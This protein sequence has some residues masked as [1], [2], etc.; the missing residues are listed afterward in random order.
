MV[1]DKPGQILL[2]KLKE[3]YSTNSKL[4][5]SNGTN[6]YS[7]QSV[8]S[9]TM[10]IDVWAFEKYHNH[11]GFYL[12]IWPKQNWMTNNQY[13]LNLRSIYGFNYFSTYHDYI[14]IAENNGYQLSNIVALVDAHFPQQVIN[15][16]NQPGTRG[17]CGFYYADEPDHIPLSFFNGLGQQIIPYSTIDSVNKFVNYVRGKY[18]PP[19]S[20]IVIGETTVSSTTKFDELV[21]F[22]TIT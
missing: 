1:I 19:N 3:K 10:E 7:V 8:S 11:S 6:A 18:P 22:A 20:K 17:P 5:K 14:Q 4:G 13:I 12:N 16:Y 21:D 9:I 2:P 15:S